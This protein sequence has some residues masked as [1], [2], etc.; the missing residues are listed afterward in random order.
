MEHQHEPAPKTFKTYWP[1]ILVLLFITGGTLHLA[2]VRSA[3]DIANLMLDFMGLFFLLF[4]FFK[5]LDV[6]GFAEA[7]GRYDIPTKIWPSWGFIYPFVELAF[8]WL[9][10]LRIELF[11]T[12]IAVVLVL[13]IS[14][15]GVIKSVLNKQQIKCAC[16]GTGFNLPM[17]QVTIVEDGVMMAMALFMIFL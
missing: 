14:I 15:V 4:A 17:T 11:W 5:L 2:S 12:N 10:L 8:A 9:Y 13:G 6:K 7:Y 3:F 1:L 16:L